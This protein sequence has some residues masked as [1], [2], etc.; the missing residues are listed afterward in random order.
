MSN[1]EVSVDFLE[2]AVLVAEVASF[3]IGTEFLSVELSA[4][5]ALIFVV[6]TDLLLT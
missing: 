6:S 4:I 1:I 3:A 5:L 2:A